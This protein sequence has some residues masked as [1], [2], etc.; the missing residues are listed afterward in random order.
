[1]IP[2]ERGTIPRQRLLRRAIRPIVR[3]PFGLALAL[4]AGCS[5]GG[6]G[7]NRNE[8]FAIHLESE[9]I[10][11][12]AVA[13][14]DS[15]RLTIRFPDN[16][17]D[18]GPEVVWHSENPAIASL[19]EPTGASVTL[20]GVS[21]GDTRVVARAG[22]LADTIVVAILGAGAGGWCD[23]DGLSLQLGQSV[24]TTAAAG[25]PLCLAA[26][27]AGAEFVVVPFNA[28][29]GGQRVRAE[30]VGE[31]V[32]AFAADGPPGPLGPDA[33]FTTGPDIAT[34]FDRRL[35]EM[36]Q[37]DLRPLS[38]GRRAPMDF[39]FSEVALDVPTVGQTIQ[40]NVNSD[41]TCTSPV[42]RAAR[43]V[44]VS[45]RAVLL[46][47]TGNPAGGFAAADYQS[48]ATAIDQQVYP[49]ITN[50]FGTPTDID[51]NNRV[52]ILFTKAVNELTPQGSVSYVAG[53]FFARDL[54]P[55]QDAPGLRGCATSNAAELLYMLAPDPN[56]VINGNKRHRE[57]IAD[58]SVGI[59]A[60]EM[61]HLVSASRRLRLLGRQEWNEKFWLGEAMSH[62]A[63]ELLF[64][65]GTP[66][67]ARS[68]ISIT[69]LRDISGA[70]SRFNQIQVPNFGRYSDYLRNTQN[71]SALVGE[72]LSTRGAAWSFLRYAADRRGGDERVLWRTL[73]DA[74]ATG[75]DNL[76]GALGASPLAWMHDWVVSL[77]TD[78]N[79]VVPSRFRQPSWHF[80]SILPLISS[81]QNAYPLAIIDLRP[82]TGARADL[83]LVSGGSAIIRFRAPAGGATRVRITSG[84]AIAPPHLRFTII[85]TR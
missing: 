19:D 85:R 73:T 15:V 32:V 2:P 3:R 51:G 45:H 62:I 16:I 50:N 46:E 84:G 78:D 58:R 13:V 72:E 82:A 39:A 36:E 38:D 80:R 44:A 4:I 23:G 31:G 8:T 27:E 48:F 69:R 67:E 17:G 60:H 28:T 33:V 65:A 40:I 63:E 49:T 6:I 29:T 5:D 41:D 75:Y 34:E 22:T 1:M 83:D 76:L 56:G 55:R 79:V 18:A 24:T 7:P 35:R 66:L 21:F 10:R 52:L 11:E 77:Y 57:E 47:D 74:N 70:L 14:G 26:V 54:F 30:V 71:G 81:N 61:Q 37:R 68:E 42:M 12:T 59:I 25:S 20:R 43:V 64:Y 9:R 53:F